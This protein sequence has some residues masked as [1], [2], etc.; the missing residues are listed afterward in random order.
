[1]CV[2]QAVEPKT[3]VPV[4]TTASSESSKPIL[5]AALPKTAQ[6]RHQPHVQDTQQSSQRPNNAADADENSIIELPV[7]LP[8]VTQENK[9]SAAA[10][11]NHHLGLG[12]KRHQSDITQDNLQSG[13]AR[14]NKQSAFT[15]E[16]HQFGAACRNHQSSDACRIQRSEAARENRPS[17][18][19]CRHQQSAVAGENFQSGAACK[20][21][22]SAGARENNQLENE[23]KSEDP[24]VA[25]DECRSGVTFKNLPTQ[26]NCN[27]TSDSTATF[28]AVVQANQS[29][30]DRCDTQQKRS[31]SADTTG[32]SVPVLN[33]PL[34]TV[35]WEKESKGAA[36]ENSQTQHVPRCSSGSTDSPIPKFHTKI[37]TV[38]SENNFTQQ[39]LTVSSNST[40]NSV[41][42]LNSTF[43]TAARENRQ[44]D[45]VYRNLEMQ[46]KLNIISDNT[47]SSVSAMNVTH[48]AAL[49]LNNQ[50]GVVRDH[51]Q[52]D[53]ICRDHTTRREL[54]ATSDNRLTG[55]SVPVLNVTFSALAQENQ[56]SG[57]A[58]RNQQQR[59]ACGQYQSSVP[60]ECCCSVQRTSGTVSVSRSSLPGLHMAYPGV[61][62]EKYQSEQKLN[63]SVSSMT[64]NSAPGLLTTCPTTGY[65]N[66]E[67]VPRTLPS[68]AQLVRPLLPVPVSQQVTYSQSQP[69]PHPQG[70]SIV[71]HRHP[72]KVA[73]PSLQP[74]HSKFSSISR[75]SVRPQLP[76]MP[77]PT[78]YPQLSP[79]SQTALKSQL[80]SVSQKSPHFQSSPVSQESPH[81]QSE[82]TSG[83]SQHFHSLPQSQTAPHYESISPHSQSLIIT[84]KF[85]HS[86]AL[87]LSHTSP[88]SQS[89]PVSQI[90]PHSQSFPVPQK[91]AHVP[92]SQ[93]SPHSQSFPV[94][95]KSAHV[96]PSLVSPHTQ[97]SQLLQ[98]SHTSPHSHL[99][100]VSQTSPK[101]QSLPFFQTS[102]SQPGVASHP[103]VDHQTL[104]VPPHVPSKTQPLQVPTDKLRSTANLPHSSAEILAVQSKTMP[105]PPRRQNILPKP[106]ESGGSQIPLPVLS[107]HTSPQATPDP[108]TVHSVE[109]PSDVSVISEFRPVQQSS[110]I[111]QEPHAVISSTSNR[112]HSNT[113]EE[114]PI[115]LSIGKQKSEAE[116]KNKPSVSVTSLVLPLCQ[117]NEQNNHGQCSTSPRHHQGSSEIQP[118]LVRNLSSEEHNVTD[119]TGILHH[120]YR[121]P[122][123]HTS[124]LQSVKN[125]GQQQQLQT[126]VQVGSKVRDP[127]NAESVSTADNSTGKDE[128][129]R[130][131]DGQ[132]RQRD[133]HR[134]SVPECS[135]RQKRFEILR[136]QN[137]GGDGGD[138]GGGGGGGGGVSHR[139]HVHVSEHHEMAH[140]SQHS[141]HQYHTHRLI[142]SSSHVPAY[143]KT[144]VHGLQSEQQQGKQTAEL[145]TASAGS[146]RRETCWS[147]NKQ[148]SSTTAVAPDRQSQD[149]R[150]VTR[151]HSHT[152]SQLVCGRCKQTARFMCS[153]CHN[154]W[155]C[156]SECQVRSLSLECDFSSSF[157]IVSSGKHELLVYWPEQILTPQRCWGLCSN[158]CQRQADF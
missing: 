115:D 130:Q 135:S 17:E 89:L 144:V 66:Q 74:S 134:T 106:P 26:Q 131:H 10:H 38:K 111:T 28:P 35:I 14:W 55:N 16:N 83:T 25:H 54:S 142:P 88:N 118:S 146:S 5:Y 43:Q 79:V 64:R 29:T 70:Q 94:P 67:A 8:A 40:G 15:H 113:V 36:S 156:S 145:H 99:S 57:F 33:T 132:G 91:S 86:Q 141:V 150:S 152:R 77:Q 2:F 41:T 139:R 124:Q 153:A 119:N 95:Q 136:D 112:L 49:R 6:E 117:H 42:Q 96:H 7:T 85:P 109:S 39:K 68:S 61:T 44:S 133:G 21:K 69:A 103:P 37:P 73:H 12:C 13:G 22:Q 9:Q 108:I 101:S 154:E 4:A 129:G 140:F 107:K 34:E 45:I 128:L 24:V 56:Q 58:C 62:C 122:H 32:S 151:E 116:G 102:H 120:N 121:M 148:V 80:L 92:V 23:G 149:T 84:Q 123:S 157:T 81:S 3:A 47:R 30:R 105:P 20:N 147:V 19:A 82:V 53:S 125:S 155:Y 48:P 100:P 11:E 52:S 18:V 78:L 87:S 90:S 63:V 50:S 97:N 59:D 137:V 65:Q 143:Q 104:Q 93:I 127:P 60:C 98:I 76:Q 1:M 72:I 114:R 126:S 31:V 110:V 46:R 27:V 51:Q 71:L 138:G 158:C 75:P